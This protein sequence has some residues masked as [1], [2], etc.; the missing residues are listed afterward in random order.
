MS[1]DTFLNDCIH[2]QIEIDKQ[3]GRQTDR[4]IDVCT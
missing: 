4:Q 2:P 1:A 3:T